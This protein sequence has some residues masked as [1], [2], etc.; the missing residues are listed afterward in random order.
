MVHGVVQGVG[1]RPFVYRLALEEGLAGFIGNDTGGVT[2]EIEGPTERVEAFRR[3]LEAEAPPLSRIDSVALIEAQ[4]TGQAGFRIHASDGAGQVSTGIPADAATCADCLR[5]L[6]DPNDRRFRYPFLN[7]TNCGPRYTITRRI[8]YDRPQTSM[9]HFTMCAACQAE[10]DDPTNRRFHAQPNACPVCGPRVW[11]VMADGTPTPTGQSENTVSTEHEVSGHDL[12]LAESDEVLKGHD[13][14]RSARSLNKNEGTSGY[15]T[16]ASGTHEVSGHDLS[17]AE[18]PAQNEGALAPAERSPIEEAID[19]L[20]AGDIMAIKGIGGFHLAVDATN[21]AA[22][23]RLRERKHRYGKPLAVMVRDLDAA[24]AV[25]ALTHEEEV[26]LQTIPRPIVLARRHADS[27]IADS[28]APGIPWLGV[29][30]PYAPLQHLLFAGSRVKA[31]VMTSANLSEE[32]ISIDNEEAI[33]RLKNIADA[34]LMHD[35]EILQRCDDSVMALVD[36]APQLIRRA[37]GFVPLGVPLPFDSPSLLAVGGHLKNVFALARG[38]F[39]YQSQH[40][41]DLENIAGL[42]FFREALEHLMH[43][44]E[45]EPEAVVH[46]LHPG[47]LSTSFAKEWAGERELPLIAVQHHH[48]HI[49]AC[50]AENAIEGPAIGLSLD[51]TG[52]GTDGRIWGGEVLILQLDGPDPA[53]FERFAHLDYVPM[54]GGE[55]AIREPWRMALGHLH[56]AGFDVESPEVL[57]LLGAKPQEVRVLRRMIEREL[58]TPPTSSCGRLFDAVAA[59]VLGRGVVDYEAQAAIELEGVC[60]DE[61][62][63]LGS[64]YAFELLHGDWN[65]RKPATISAKP[66]WKELLNDLRSNK[67][68]S[69]IAARFHAGVAAAFIAAA[70]MARENSGIKK[71]A[72][73]G[74]CLHNRRLARLLRADLEKESFQVFEHR[75]VSP[76]DGGLSYGQAVIAAAI[77]KKRKAEG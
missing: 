17:R 60:I 12:S 10:Y 40:L 54:P 21:E 49:A 13:L 41:G 75:T 26:L 74:G 37:R 1:F 53:E 38:R 7:C 50:M 4:V 3:R 20:M 5:E 14:S 65:A 31:L 45:I 39:A 24:R 51:G 63:Q 16:A 71:V 2:I 44:F 19:R 67:S 70:R 52:Y 9:A 25:C 35:R 46:D 47:Y 18:N 64:G 34:F 15:T 66:L 8:P 6:L 32:P 68:K 62:D 36:G 69:L 22:V 61:P 76:G 58:N 59:V 28:V 30:L 73:S 56:H 27:G 48:A 57:A 43:T 55:A 77:L 72:L 33:Q 11:L 42:D 29:F 23:I